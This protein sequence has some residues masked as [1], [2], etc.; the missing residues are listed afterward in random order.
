MVTWY[1]IFRFV[2]V[3]T[4][5]DLWE[6]L[7]SEHFCPDLCILSGTS[8]SYSYVPIVLT[9]M[10]NSINRFNFN[11]QLYTV[12]FPVYNATSKPFIKD[13]KIYLLL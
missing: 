8:D 7:H 4:A 3:T 12:K 13:T 5:E 6:I 11:I 10:Y 1:A 9:R 2:N